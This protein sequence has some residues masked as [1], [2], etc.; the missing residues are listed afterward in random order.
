MYLNFRRW[1]MEQLKPLLN[2]PKKNLWSSISKSDLSPL[3][4]GCNGH[5]K[6]LRFLIFAVWKHAGSCLYYTQAKATNNSLGTSERS[7]GQ[8]LLLSYQTNLKDLEDKGKGW[9][10]LGFLDYFRRKEKKEVPIFACTLC[11]LGPLCAS[12]LKSHSHEIPQPQSCTPRIKTCILDS[13]HWA[14]IP[15]GRG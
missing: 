6:I 15:F 9:F 12:T 1:K 4:A 8:C 7:A 3:Y 5:T 11:S 10:E 2:Y 14:L 13:G